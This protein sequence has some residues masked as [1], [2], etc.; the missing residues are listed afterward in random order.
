MTQATSRVPAREFK[1]R[2]FPLK[3]LHSSP[4]AVSAMELGS[5]KL[6]MMACDRAQPLNNAG[7][8]DWI[9]PRALKRNINMGCKCSFQM[10]L[11][12]RDELRSKH[13]GLGLSFRTRLCVAGLD[14]SLKSERTWTSSEP[15]LPGLV[16]WF[17]RLASRRRPPAQVCPLLNSSDH[18]GDQLSNKQAERGDVAQSMALA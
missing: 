10:S 9:A 2:G 17:A 5:K 14:P 8:A 18:G 3:I 15:S 4:R 16:Q 13:L 12:P 7:S 6:P 1:E 11:P